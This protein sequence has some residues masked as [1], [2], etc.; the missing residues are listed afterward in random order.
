MPADTPGAEHRRLLREVLELQTRVRAF[1]SSR[2]WRLHPRFAL[3]RLLSRSPGPS[4]VE[5]TRADRNE[6]LPDDFDE[7][8]AE[9]WRRVAPY[10]MTTPGKMHVLARAVEYI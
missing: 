4:P 1:E 10:T 3:G 6:P 8:D 2:W 7:A 9:L 5:S